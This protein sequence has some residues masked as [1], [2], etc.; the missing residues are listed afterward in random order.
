MIHVPL[1]K[2]VLKFFSPFLH[3]LA[4][5]LSGRPLP[6]LCCGKH[7]RVV[8]QKP[9][10]QVWTSGVGERAWKETTTA[11]HYTL[12]YIIESAYLQV[13][14]MIQLLYVTSVLLFVRVISM[15]PGASPKPGTKRYSFSLSNLM[16]THHVCC[17]G[18]PILIVVILRQNC[19]NHQN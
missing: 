2:N 17:S 13:H 7:W 12:P 6:W 16:E 18:D 5:C 1:L 4:G 3:T 8:K 14:V 9:F 10:S 15:H 11:S 19:E